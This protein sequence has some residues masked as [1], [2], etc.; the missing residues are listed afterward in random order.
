MQES[1]QTRG[2][3]IVFPAILRIM[4]SRANMDKLNHFKLIINLV[5]NL[6]RGNG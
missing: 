5:K 2:K 4:T 6:I 3:S 1:G